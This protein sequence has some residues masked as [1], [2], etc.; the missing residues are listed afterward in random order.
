MVAIYVLICCYTFQ[1][2]T[3]KPSGCRFMLHFPFSPIAPP[4]FSASSVEESVPGVAQLHVEGLL[5]LVGCLMA[6]LAHPF[7]AGRF[8]CTF[9]SP[10]AVMLSWLRLKRQVAKVKVFVALT[11]KDGEQVR[12]TV[13]CQTL[14]QRFIHSC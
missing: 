14:W 6:T 5:S 4:P 10:Y 13:S 2:Q 11:G 9:S 12:I 7:Q 3:E 8:L 1:N